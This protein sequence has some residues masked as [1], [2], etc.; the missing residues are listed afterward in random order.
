MKDIRTW[1]EKHTIIEVITH[2]GIFVAIVFIII[3]I[4][5]VLAPKQMNEQITYI[6]CCNGQMCTDTYYTANDNQCHLSL[7]ESKA[8]LFNNNCTYDGANKTISLE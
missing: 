8:W 3:Y 5:G 2:V 4:L 7:C 6:Q 1:L